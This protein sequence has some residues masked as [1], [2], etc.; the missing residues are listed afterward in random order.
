MF[1]I[2]LLGRIDLDRTRV[3][4]VFIEDLVVLDSHTVVPEEVLVDIPLHLRVI[5]DRCV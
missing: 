4:D 5:R 2:T 1:L 3:M